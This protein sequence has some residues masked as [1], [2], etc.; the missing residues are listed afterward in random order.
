MF[1]E[2]AVMADITA[3]D[4]ERARDVHC[5]LVRFVGGLEDGPFDEIIA[6]ALALSREIGKQDGYRIGYDEGVINGA[7]EQREK[8][9]ER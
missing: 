7:R 5:K 2:I 4:R 1:R 8:D 9:V 6:A 3:A